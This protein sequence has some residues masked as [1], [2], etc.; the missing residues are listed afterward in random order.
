MANDNGAASSMAAVILAGSDIAMMVSVI[1]GNAKIY[2]SVMAQIRVTDL[3]N[4]V[5]MFPGEVV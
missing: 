3:F 4:S 2:I 1:C 5:C